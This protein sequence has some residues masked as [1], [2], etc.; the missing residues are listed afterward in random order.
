MLRCTSPSQCDI[1]V[2]AS[3]AYLSPPAPQRTLCTLAATL[4]SN[5]RERATRQPITPYSPTAQ[6]LKAPEDKKARNPPLA[7]LFQWYCWSQIPSSFAILET[8][9]VRRLTMLRSA[10]LLILCEQY[11]CFS[12]ALEFSRRR[13]RFRVAAT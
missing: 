11:R 1:P 3:R 5:Q 4:A 7:L 6:C 13:L 8:A 12:G 10:G 9:S 2:K